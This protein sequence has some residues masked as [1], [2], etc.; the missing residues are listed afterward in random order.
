MMPRAIELYSARHDTYGHS[1]L[2][3]PTAVGLGGDIRRLLGSASAT[4]IT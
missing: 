4:R 3:E 1:Q 2:S